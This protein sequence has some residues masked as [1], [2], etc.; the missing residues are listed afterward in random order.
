MMENIGN[1]ALLVILFSVQLFGLFSLLIPGLP[2]LT[3]IWV[4]VLVF[5][6]VRGFE[7]PGLLYFI[8]ITVLM[9]AGNIADNLLMGAGAR[10]T[11][12][13]WISIG[14]ALGAGILGSILAP[15]LG[16]LILAV[17]G[18]FLVEF[19]RHKDWRKAFTSTRSMAAGC[20][21]AVVA[22]F[23]IGLLMILLWVIWVL[24][25]NGGITLG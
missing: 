1:I 15:P 25:Q 7:W 19:I 21:W 13:S 20:G 9:L 17:G 23:F 5:G 6:F 10:R 4:S 3:V 14:V 2:G 11:G 16:G 18:I 22:R 24:V 12:A 8:F